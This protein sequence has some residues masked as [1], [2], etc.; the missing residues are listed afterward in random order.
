MSDNKA[1]IRENFER[2]LA[3]IEALKADYYSIFPDDPFVCISPDCVFTTKEK[4]AS[5]WKWAIEHKK[6]WFDCPFLPKA[7]HKSNVTYAMRQ[8]FLQ[9]RKGDNNESQH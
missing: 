6:H 4:E 7:F 1:A 9:R 5:M 2:A 3:E 8:D